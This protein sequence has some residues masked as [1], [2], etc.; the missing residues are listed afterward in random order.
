[1]RNLIFLMFLMT[2][3]IANAQVAIN[4]DGATPDN[5]ALLDV[6]STTMGMLFPR[7]TQSQR[8]AI[9]SPATGLTIYQT[10]NTPGIYV[11]S[12]SPG[13]P[14]WIMAGSGGSWSTAGN[15]GTSAGTNFIGTSDAQPLM[16]KVNNQISGLI[17]NSIPFNTGFGYQTLNSLGGW[18]TSAFGYQA[19]FSN[20]N[21]TGNTAT[22]C[23]ALYAN[24]DGYNNT[25]SGSGT[26]GSNTTASKNTAIG[27]MALSSQS[28]NPGYYWESD[29]VAV[30][31][32]A[33]LNDQPAS[34][35]NGI[36]N[37]AVG[38]HSLEANTQGFQNTSVGANSLVN[39]T[40]GSYNTAVGYNT[41]PNAAN[42]DNTLCVGIDATATATNMVRIGN[43]FVNS[44][45]GYAD[46][47]NIS[48]SRFKENVRE[49][50]PG[51]AFI[52]QLRPVSYQLNREK[53]N[54]FTGVTARQDELRKQDPAIKC[55]T[56]E[57]YSQ[58]TTGFIAQEVEA[59]AR[60]VGFDFSGVDP[61]KNENDYYGLRYAEFVVPLVK[62]VQEQQ[63][64]IETQEITNQELNRKVENLEQQVAQLRQIIEKSVNK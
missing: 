59:A 44:I 27:A 3:L 52:K 9:A 41:G 46:W 58:V 42:L 55:L 43:I 49:D 64:M 1:M 60:S 10:D 61:P 48:D 45:G 15:S 30:G 17:E 47:T 28:Y 7:M 6:K 56:G 5:S 29:N 36:K 20:T 33:L 53:I 40:T 62:A 39:N 21:G 34:I 51:L 14:A 31:F 23:K 8:D 2:G 22:G 63:K 18:F 57:K 38:T 35:A 16:F 32:N 24:T 26:L 12:G 11:N 50:I 19:L 13:S 25:A 54:K 4:T 37:T